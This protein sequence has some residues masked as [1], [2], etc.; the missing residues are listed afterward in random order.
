MSGR[1]R[2]LAYRADRIPT[3][4][5]S[6]LELTDP[7]YRGRVGWAP[8]NASFQTALTALRA[9]AGEEAAEAWLRGMIANETRVYRKNSPIITALAAGEI[10]LGL[11]NHYYLLQAQ[12]Q[13]R[14]TQVSQRFFTNGDIGN[15][16]NVAGI[17][18]LGAGANQEAAE[19]LLQFL[20]GDEAQRFFAEESFEY[21]VVDGAPTPQGLPAG[22][23]LKTLRAPLEIDRLRDLAGSLSLLRK[24]GLL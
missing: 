1:A 2:V 23:A 12:A 16:I 17:G 13:G 7:R 20:L 3:P 18:R 21:P 8:G 24:V 19:A 4:P 10:D 11:P 15:L 5:S 22:G 6:L 14:A 9:S